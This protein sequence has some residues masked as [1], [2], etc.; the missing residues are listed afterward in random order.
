M[1]GDMNIQNGC[2]LLEMVDGF[3]FPHEYRCSNS[4]QRRLLIEELWE[5]DPKKKLLQ[6]D[7]YGDGSVRTSIPPRTVA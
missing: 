6:I 4:E 2:W 3:R 7:V 1:L 5:Q